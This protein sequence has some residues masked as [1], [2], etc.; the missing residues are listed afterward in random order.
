MGFSTIYI[1]IKRIN[2]QNI[3][4]FEKLE[5]VYSKPLEYFVVL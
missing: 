4:L 1:H 2:N 3:K 5:L